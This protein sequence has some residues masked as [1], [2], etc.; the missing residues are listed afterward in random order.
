LVEKTKVL[1]HACAKNKQFKNFVRF[2]SKC[3]FVVRKRRCLKENV[4]KN[5]HNFLR[6]LGICGICGIY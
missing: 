1:Y 5:I 6:R 3:N 4:S 2:Q